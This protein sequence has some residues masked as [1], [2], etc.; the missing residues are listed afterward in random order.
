MGDKD[1]NEEAQLFLKVDDLPAVRF[2]E[3]PDVSLNLA[4]TSEKIAK[5]FSMLGLSF[6][7]AGSISSD[8]IYKLLFP[9]DPMETNN[10]R[11]MH[12]MPKYRRSRR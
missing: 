8:R 10:Y 11:K 2:N 5:A 9:F 4:E 1:E 12:H 6:Q 7:A 3:I